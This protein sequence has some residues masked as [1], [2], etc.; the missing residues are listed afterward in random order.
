M[1]Y[2]T[3]LFLSFCMD[4]GIAETGIARGSPPGTTT[5]VLRFG[6]PFT[7]FRVVSSCA[8]PTPNLTKKLKDRYSEPETG[9]RMRADKNSSRRRW[10]L[11]QD[12][13]N[14]QHTSPS[15]YPS[16]PSPHS[17][18]SATGPRNQ[19]PTSQTW[20]RSRTQNSSLT[21]LHQSG[22]WAPPVIPVPAGETWRL[23]QNNSTPVRLVQHTGQT[24][25]S[26]KAP[27]H[28]TGL[29]SSKTTQT[30]NKS[31]TGQQRTHSNV[32]PSKTQ[33]GS[34]PV[35]PVMHTLKFPISGCE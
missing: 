20:E 22:R 10:R 17:H 15:Y 6:L 2:S 30:R 4:Y 29:P 5:E 24:G 7:E 32:D 9:E 28:Q 34:T 16:W 1:V 26:Q 19:L 31:N 3:L 33:Q 11:Q 12:E 35:R 21:D 25:P 27:K 14:F 23:P 18:F 8:T 13:H